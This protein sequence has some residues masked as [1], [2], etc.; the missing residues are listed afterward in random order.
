MVEGAEGRREYVRISVEQVRRYRP[1]K[2]PLETADVIER[3]GHQRCGIRHLLLLLNIRVEDRP[4]PVP[5]M[6]VQRD[7]ELQK[8]GIAED[9]IGVVHP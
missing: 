5:E 4:E 1:E 9:R 7:V 3:C 6:L 8:H 2:P